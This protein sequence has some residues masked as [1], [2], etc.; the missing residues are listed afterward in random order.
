MSKKMN[1]EEL[2]IAEFNKDV[3][4][5]AAIYTKWG[6]S[7]LA[8]FLH[9]MA[10]SKAAAEEMLTKAV[11]TPDEAEAVLAEYRE[12]SPVFV[13]SA[14]NTV[15]ANSILEGLT[16]NRAKPSQDRAKSESG[17]ADVN[18]GIL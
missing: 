3:E 9:T 17:T 10:Q 14:P 7:G 15:I 6:V 5:V 1:K 8:G 4:T 11:M 16:E 12:S 18:Q 13:G 2:I